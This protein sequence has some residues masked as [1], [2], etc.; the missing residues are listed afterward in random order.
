[1]LTRVERLREQLA[2]KNLTGILVTN[3]YNRLYLSHFT[4][5]EGLLLILQAKAYLCTDFRYLEQA[6]QEAPG[7]EV[8]K[9]E[10]PWTETVKKLVGPGSRIAF[11]AESLTYARYR[12][13]EQ[14]ISG[15]EWVAEKGLVEK[16]RAQK[17]AE[18]IK[19]LREAIRL[20]DEGDLYLRSLLKPGLSEKDVA[21]E[22]EFYLRR[23]GAT[24]PSFPFIVVSGPRSSLPHGRP[25]GRRLVPGDIV[26][27]DFGIVYDGYCSDLTR[28]FILGPP[29]AQ[30]KALYDLVLTAQERALALAGPGVAAASVDAAAREVIAR[31]GYG[32]YF[33]HS[34][35]HGVGLEIH[36][37]PHLSSSSTEE[38]QPGMVVTIEPGVYLP[39]LGG[40]RI[41]DVILITEHGREILFQAPKHAF[42][43]QHPEYAL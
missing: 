12:E 35:G 33:G 19:R 9:L 10:R 23:K 34:L 27:V 29:T 40:V 41:E 7:W 1:M 20:T 5:S 21:L 43:L 28:T 15:V 18:E 8:V 16:L 38:L 13:L 31:A 32:E 17:D 14:E 26:T 2:Q 37:A 36:E 30:Q 6:A 11:E 24:E 39:G 25:S 22:L 3:P 4:G 42:V